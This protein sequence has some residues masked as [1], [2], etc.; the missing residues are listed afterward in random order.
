MKQFSLSSFHA[1]SLVGSNFF[2]FFSIS[3]MFWT[4]LLSPDHNDGKRDCRCH[5]WKQT[6]RT[7]IKLTRCRNSFLGGTFQFKSPEWVVIISFVYFL[8]ACVFPSP[9]GQHRVFTYAEPKSWQ[10][11]T[12]HAKKLAMPSKVTTFSHSKQ[13]ELIVRF[14]VRKFAVTRSQQQAIR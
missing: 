7:E 12:L 9:P 13:P 3:K 1:G 8:C 14:S 5:V 11:W 4:T 6:G 2:F 10:Y